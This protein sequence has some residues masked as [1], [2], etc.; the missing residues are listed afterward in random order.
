MSSSSTY[1][2]S[3]YL[4]FPLKNEIIGKTLLSLLPFQEKKEVY[5]KIALKEPIS[6]SD[7][8][9][10]LSNGKFSDFMRQQTLQRVMKVMTLEPI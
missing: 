9:R 3:Y 4:S 8:D 1:N 7:T 5:K 2:K 10:F 6:D